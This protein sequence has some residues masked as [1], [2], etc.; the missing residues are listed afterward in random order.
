MKNEKLRDSN[1]FVLRKVSAYGSTTHH[2]E[3]HQALKTLILSHSSILLPVSTPI[4]MASIGN[5]RLCRCYTLMTF[6]PLYPTQFDIRQTG[7]DK[8]LL[9]Q[10]NPCFPVQSSRIRA[11]LKAVPAHATPPHLMQSALYQTTK[12]GCHGKMT[13]VFPHF[14]LPEMSLCHQAYI[15]HPLSQSML[16]RQ[17]LFCNLFI[18]TIRIIFSKLGNQIG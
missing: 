13:T 8:L 17:A 7:F 14:A 11:T 3:P 2:D 15:A 16:I 10:Q 12:N 4:P 6:T 9:Y 5:C 18:C 1:L